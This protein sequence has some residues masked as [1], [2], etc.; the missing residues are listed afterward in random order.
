LQRA[1]LKKL[2]LGQDYASNFALSAQNRAFPGF[3]KPEK[4]GF[5]E[6]WA[7]WKQAFHPLFY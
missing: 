4:R 7:N 5:F 6:V 1:L 3:C 2:L